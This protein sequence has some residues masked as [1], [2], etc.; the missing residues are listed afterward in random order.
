MFMKFVVKLVDN[1]TL[2]L[3]IVFGFVVIGILISITITHSKLPNPLWLKHQQ[4]L[5]DMKNSKK[6]NDIHRN[7]K[8]TQK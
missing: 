1:P 4:F 7:Q 8:K 2:I 6:G 5:Q 3:L